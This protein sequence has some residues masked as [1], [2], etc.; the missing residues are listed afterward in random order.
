MGIQK[1]NERKEKS[2]TAAGMAA[3][4][5]AA[6]VA[7]IC[8]IGPIAAAF[9]GLTSMGAL[10]R[11]ERFRPLFTGVTLI[12][13]VGAFYLTYRRRPAAACESD[14]ICAT[15]PAPVNRINRVVLWAVA[16]IALIVLTFPT[17]S[18]WILG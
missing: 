15:H 6:L 14:S 16:A 5:I 12:F 13:L 8:C 1:M 10:V 9:L 11:Y 3:S 4:V 18:N 2:L 17:W 7:S